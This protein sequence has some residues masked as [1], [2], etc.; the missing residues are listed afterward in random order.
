[1]LTQ[2]AVTCFKNSTNVYSAKLVES[3]IAFH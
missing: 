3:S 1:M 2:P